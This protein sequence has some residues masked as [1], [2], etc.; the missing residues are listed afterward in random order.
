MRK[1]YHLVINELIKIFAKKAI[2]VV[3][4]G[5]IIFVIGIAYST[6]S[7]EVEDSWENNA[8][9]KLIELNKQLDEIEP[10]YQYLVENDIKELEYYI[11]NGINPYEENLWSFTLSNI[12]LIIIITLFMVIISSGIM[13]SEYSYRT[14]KHLLTRPFSR[15]YILLAKYL[16]I[17][18][19]ALLLIFELIVVSL[20]IGSISF[21]FDSINSNFVVFNAIGEPSIQIYSIYILKRYLFEFISMMIIMTISFMLSTIINSSSLA[22]IIGISTMFSLGTLTNLFDNYSWGKYLLFPNMNLKQ[23]L[24]NELGSIEGMTLSFSISIDIIYILL[25]LLITWIIFKKKEIKF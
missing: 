2:Y 5:L 7:E 4:I 11:D 12:N 6:K 23:Y 9:S 20:I 13:S 16:A 19:V 24:D 21:G 3:A 8:N 22:I 25:F 18:V 15:F 10:E 17:N 1:L 14:I